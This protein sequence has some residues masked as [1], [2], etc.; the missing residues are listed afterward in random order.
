[1][2]KVL[3]IAYYFPP[4][5]GAG[6]QRTV[7]FVKYLSKYGWLPTIVT[8][9]NNNYYVRD[10]SLLEKIN[11][12][13]K[14]IRIPGFEFLNYYNKAKN[15]KLHKIISL[16]DKITSIP[17]SQIFWYFNTKK[18]LRSVNELINYD[19]I[20][21]TFGPGSNLLIGKW[22]KKYLKLPFI[23][24]FRDEWANSPQINS[25]IWLRVKKPIFNKLEMKCVN[26]SDKII[27]LNKVMKNNFLIRY[28]NEKKDKFEVI[29]NGYD[30]DD[31]KMVRSENITLFSEEKFNI[32]YTGSFYGF[33]DPSIFLKALLELINENPVYKEKVRI[34]F[35]GNVKTPDFLNMVNRD[36]FKD[37]IRILAYV[38][39]NKLI[40]YLVS[41]DI[42]LLII[43]DMPGSDVIYTGKIFEYMV[44]GKP[45]LAVVP[46]NGVAAQLIRKTN[47]GFIVDNSDVIAIKDTIKLLFLKWEKD[48]LCINQDKKEMAKYSAENLTK[49]LVDVFETELGN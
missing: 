9:A 32:L 12:E 2:K 26:H 44:A 13:I 33:Q 35:I 30:E 42:L 39:H 28:P 10:Y 16:F 36:D 8:T 5:G 7:R 20:Y 14:I 22:L 49:K 23:I 47:S 3:I 41:A 29:P 45:I 43:G 15:F 48:G 40:K 21:A 38:Q 18:N 34:Y 46:P 6:V 1:M 27:C 11:D 25:K 37:L 4:L 24:D 17:D 31:F 19:L